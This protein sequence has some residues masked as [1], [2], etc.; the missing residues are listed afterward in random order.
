MRKRKIEWPISASLELSNSVFLSAVVASRNRLLAFVWKRVPQEKVCSTGGV[1]PWSHCGELKSPIMGLGKGGGFCLVL[2]FA[3][4]APAFWVVWG[5]SVRFWYFFIPVKNS[6][7]EGRWGTTLRRS[8]RRLLLSAITEI[9]V[10]N[11]KYNIDE[12]RK[13]DSKTGG[14]VTGPG[15]NGNRRECFTKC[16][17]HLHPNSNANTVLN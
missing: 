17:S 15:E 14:L 6:Q 3:L 13:G 5:G 4:R 7:T 12:Q 11:S 16:S 2:D 8:G 10:G 1:C 9:Q